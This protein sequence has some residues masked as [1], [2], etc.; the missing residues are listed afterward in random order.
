MKTI[1]T[2]VAIVGAGPA[3]L[4]LGHL[5]HLAGIDSVIVEDRAKE[6]VIERVRAGV[7]EQGSVDLLI[8]SGVGD[9]LQCEGLFHDGVFI[10]IY[11]K[12]HRIDFAALTGRRI[13]V[14]GQNEVVKDLI[15]ARVATGRPLHFEVSDV[16]VHD[17]DSAEPKIHFTTSDE[18]PCEIRCDFVAGCDGFHGICRPSIENYVRAYERVYPF[19]WLGILAQ[20]PP[21]SSELVYSRHNHGFALFS[22]R[23]SSVTRL[24]L[25][26]SPEEDLEQWP[27]DRIWEEL[28]VRL[29]SEDG[30]APNVGTIT[31]KSVTGMR[32]FVTEP[33]QYG[34]M[35]LAGDAAHIV[36]PTGA[37]GLNLAMADV[38]RLSRAITDYYHSRSDQ[39]LRR[40]SEDCLWRVWRAQHFSWWMTS[41]LHKSNT[42][43]PFDCR[44]QRA[45]LEH[46]VTSPAAMTNLA[47][48]YVG[49]PVAYEPT[50][51]LR[52]RDACD[53]NLTGYR[54]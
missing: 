8:E 49:F 39:L 46:V 10:N 51:E 52:M 5:L 38:W 54:S 26:C 24:Y 7:L 23:S 44:R 34:R 22:M 53:G 32:S 25:Q 20:A 37:K 11:G 47:E 17:L 29:G 30:W 45:E 40:Y 18:E 42:G 28:L 3:G 2:Q 43:N 31:Q 33:M 50:G 16:S 1:R 13:T 36:P 48:N 6:Y 14:Y 21:S 35:F 19:G 27:D 4:M 9:R 41:L 12:R 15:A